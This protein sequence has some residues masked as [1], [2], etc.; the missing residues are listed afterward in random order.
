MS[1][2][3]EPHGHDFGCP[4]PWQALGTQLPGSVQFWT[5]KIAWMSAVTYAGGSSAASAVLSLSTK[6]MYFV[7]FASVERGAQLLSSSMLKPRHL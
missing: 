6:P 2:G 7:R 1:I 4:C 3:A 5:P